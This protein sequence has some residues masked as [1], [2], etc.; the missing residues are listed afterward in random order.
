VRLEYELLKRR[1]AEM[2]KVEDEYK[3]RIQRVALA[4]RLVEERRRK[5]EQEL[6]LKEL[7]RE[8]LLKRTI[9]DQLRKDREDREEREIKALREREE[10][11]IRER[12][13]KEDRERRWREERMERED[14]L[15]RER[16]ER[17]L[18]IKLEWEEREERLKREREVKKET[19]MMRWRLDTVAKE[20]EIEQ[21]WLENSVRAAQ[22]KLGFL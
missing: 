17:E 9:V 21:M 14:R 8:I 16:E 13:E 3:A 1:A 10:K 4:E 11:M 5:D 18:K 6:R 19:E 22:L 20:R 2:K 7:E 12:Q 15:R